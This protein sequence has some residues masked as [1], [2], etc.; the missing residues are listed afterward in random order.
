MDLGQFAHRNHVVDHLVGSNPEIVVCH[1]VGA[2]HDNYCLGME[3]DDVG[4]EAHQHM[5]RGLSSDTS[6]EVVMGGEELGMEIRPVL[7]DGGAHENYVWVCFVGDNPFVVSFIIIK[8][9]PVL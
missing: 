7:G 8:A 6:S 1:V 2:R 4:L 3:V 9:E 5:G